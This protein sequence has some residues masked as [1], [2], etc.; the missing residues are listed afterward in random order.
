MDEL[1]ATI[2]QVDTKVGEEEKGRERAASTL[3]MKTE[4]LGQELRAL[5]SAERSSRADQD[6]KL[7][8]DTIDAVQK[9]ITARQDADQS[10]VKQLTQRMEKEE[11]D[12]REQ[13]EVQA[14]QI[15]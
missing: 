3:E 8:N 6:E 12:L 4:S 5:I 9:E 1:N 11:A 10:L 14:N 15:R 2:N 13:V 7:R